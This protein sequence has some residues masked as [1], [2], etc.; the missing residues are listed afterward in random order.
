M[1][2]IKKLFSFEEIIG[3]KGKEIGEGK[4]TKGWW[5]MCESAR[6][7]KNYISKSASEQQRKE[8][9]KWEV[10]LFSGAITFPIFLPFK[11]NLWQFFWYYILFIFNLTNHSILWTKI[12]NDKYWDKLIRWIRSK[13]S[14]QIEKF[15][16]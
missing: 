12:G 11:D 2:F 3:K 9:I 15:P 16:K 13:N 10:F 4:E 14:S 8:K 1:V 6:G 5:K 7:N